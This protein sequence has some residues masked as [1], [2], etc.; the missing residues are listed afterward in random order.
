MRANRMVR[1]RYTFKR[2]LTEAEAA[3]LTML[4]GWRRDSFVGTDGSGAVLV[5]KARIRLGTLRQRESK[6]EARSSEQKVGKFEPRI[7]GSR[8]RGS[9]ESR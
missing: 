5:G 8:I 9:R 3:L 4:I 7:P 1:N 6:D 2:A